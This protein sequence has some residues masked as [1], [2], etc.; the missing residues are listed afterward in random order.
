[1]SILSKLISPALAKGTWNSGLLATEAGTCGRALSD[2]M[3]SIAGT[4]MQAELIN[5]L[6]LP[7]MFCMVA[8]VAITLRYYHLF[9]VD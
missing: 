1:M 2:I 4:S 3:I 7:S 8:A 6:F 9:D 5:A